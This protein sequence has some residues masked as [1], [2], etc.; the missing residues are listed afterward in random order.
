MK[1][2]RG[3]LSCSNV[4]PWV[5]SERRGIKFLEYESQCFVIFF[6]RFSVTYLGCRMC[7]AA[8]ST[9]PS[10]ISLIYILSKVG[11]LRVVHLDF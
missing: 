2:L 10:K 5:T 3:K 4:Y 1:I 6:F 8:T 9:N 11:K 7:L